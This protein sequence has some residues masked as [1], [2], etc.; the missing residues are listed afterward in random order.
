MHFGADNKYFIISFFSQAM[1]FVP[2]ASMVSTFRL[3]G[4]SETGKTAYLFKKRKHH[5]EHFLDTV[6]FLSK[7]HEH[8]E[9][10]SCFPGLDML[11]NNFG[12]LNERGVMRR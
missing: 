1:H 11:K 9:I 12:S 2:P 4:L 3:T 7:Y 8:R 10:H 5:V 6:W